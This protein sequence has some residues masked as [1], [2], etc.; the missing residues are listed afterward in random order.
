MALNMYHCERHFSCRQLRFRNKKALPG[1]ENQKVVPLR[2][3]MN[4]CLD[5]GNTRTKAGVFNGNQ[6]IDQVIVADWRTGHLRAFAD[7]HPLQNA[8]VASVAERDPAMVPTFTS[9]GL[10]VLEMAPET[11]IPFEN[12]YTTPQTLGIDRLA[13]VSGV[14]ALYPGQNVLVIDAG[15][16]IKYDGLSAQGVYIGGNIAPGLHMRIRAMH[17]QTARLPMVSMYIP[18]D[19]VGKSTETA[20]QNGAFKGAVLELSGFISLF[21]EKWP[22]LLV[23][24]SGGDALFLFEAIQMPGVLLQPDLLLIGLNH[25]LN[26]NL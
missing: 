1:I 5:I 15:T 25:I 4:L 13:A 26:H 22:D 14:H 18:A 17:E 8:I 11:P 21:A 12:A 23:V 3:L 7:A 16:C 20:L 24:L 2:P 9:W 6:L 19:F 10:D